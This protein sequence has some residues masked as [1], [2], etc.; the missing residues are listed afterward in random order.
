MSPARRTYNL[1]PTPATDRADVVIPP[2]AKA[3]EDWSTD[4]YIRE[5]HE[6]YDA[7][8]ARVKAACE[9]ECGMRAQCLK[10]FGDM[11]GLV[12]SG[13]TGIERGVERKPGGSA[14]RAK[15]RKGH[16]LTTEGARHADGGCATCSRE[17]AKGQEAQAS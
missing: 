15:C 2:C 6:E 7:R 13:L 14:K 12:V 9:T 10:E 4:R 8:I 5:S 1:A 11:P 17:R 16:D 3:P